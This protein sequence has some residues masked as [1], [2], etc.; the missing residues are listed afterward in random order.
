M[1]KPMF[2]G[3]SNALRDGIVGLATPD[4]GLHDTWL[5]VEPISGQTLDY[6]FRLGESTNS[7]GGTPPR[8][9]TF[10]E[11]RPTVLL[12]YLP[13]QPRVQPLTFTSR[14]CP[15]PSSTSRTLTGSRPSC[16]PC[17]GWTGTRPRGAWLHEYAAARR[18][19]A[20]RRGRA[21]AAFVAQRVPRLPTHRPS[22]RAVMTKSRT[23]RAASTTRGTSCW[24]RAGGESPWPSPA[25]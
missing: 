17:C 5:G 21:R 25:A 13:I 3:A 18:A 9:R 6:H 15:C 12:S 10:V 7:W 16:S 1:S 4:A 22:T 20:H 11:S 19:R 8:P 24:R 2:L 23:S 14:P